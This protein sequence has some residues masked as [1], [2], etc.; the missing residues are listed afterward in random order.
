MLI[1]TKHNYYIIRVILSLSRKC[2]YE[3]LFG[4]TF[5]N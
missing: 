4:E 2:W 1:F 3:I 5:W